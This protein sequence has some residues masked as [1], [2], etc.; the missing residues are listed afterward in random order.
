MI[1]V[2]IPTQNKF[3]DFAGKCKALYEHSQKAIT[4][5][6]SFEFIINNTF[7]YLFT[8]NRKLI[9]AVYYFVDNEGKLMLNGFSKRKTHLLNIKCLKMSLK[10]FNKD[11]YAEAQNRASA[12]CLLRCGFKRI[13]KSHESKLFVYKP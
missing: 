4:D 10:W 8:E 13:D 5:S 6:N 11:I 7:F 1:E 12:F 2:W 3:W 9:G